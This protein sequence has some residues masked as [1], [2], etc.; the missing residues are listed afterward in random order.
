MCYNSIY[1]KDAGQDLTTDQINKLQNILEQKEIS[2][3]NI[4]DFRY[5]TIQDVK[6][7]LGLE[8]IK[9][10][11]DKLENKVN[12]IDDLESF[13]LAR[14]LKNKIE[15]EMQYPGTIKITVVRETRAQEEAK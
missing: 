5:F 13:K 9:Y 3:A 6:N 10:I 12:E 2:Y 11:S 15:A 14:E 4:S 7:I 8:E 1:I